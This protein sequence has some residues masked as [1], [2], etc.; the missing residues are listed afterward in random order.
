[1]GEHYLLRSLH[2]PVNII[3]PPPNCPCFHCIDQKTGAETLIHL[4][5]VITRRRWNRGTQM[6]K[7]SPP[8]SPA[9][10]P[11]REL[12]VGGGTGAVTNDPY[13]TRCRR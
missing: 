3:N 6:L 12:S 9:P 7:L 11:T 8:L 2:V 4:D 10:P 13:L 1:M 5:K